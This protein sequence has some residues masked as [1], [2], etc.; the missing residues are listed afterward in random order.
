MKK[1]LT[2]GVFDLLHIGHLKLFRRAKEYGD[3]LIVAVHNDTQKIKNIDFLYTLEE[4]IDFISAL[5]IVDKTVVYERVDKLVSSVDFDVFVYG[6]DQNHEYFQKAF[7]WCRDNDKE[8]IMLER[9]KGISSSLIRRI[10][11]KKEV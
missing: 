8:L 1:I 2:V 6:E 9:T 5:K 10:L 4:R 3:F 7:N 11:E